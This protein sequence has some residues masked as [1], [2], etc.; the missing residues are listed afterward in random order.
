MM[1]CWKEEKII[2]VQEVARRYDTVQH[3]TYS[4]LIKAEE[5]NLLIG[6][7]CWKNIVEALKKRYGDGNI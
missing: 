7:A 5:K 4:T 1:Y 2:A 3:S 6:G